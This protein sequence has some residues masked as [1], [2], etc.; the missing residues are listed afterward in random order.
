M[1][2]GLVVLLKI[3]CLIENNALLAFILRVFSATEN[4]ALLVNI[5]PKYL[6]RLTYSNSSIPTTNLN[7]FLTKR[8]VSEK[9]KK[10]THDF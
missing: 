9:K 1:E 7:L 4:L 5:T 8:P 3:L 2:D 6:Y 10:K